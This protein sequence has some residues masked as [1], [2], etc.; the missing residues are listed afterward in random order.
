MNK[1]I[2]SDKS[3]ISRQPG[4]PAGT[5][6]ALRESLLDAALNLFAELGAQAT[7]LRAICA[8]TGV[9]PA[10]L[11]YYF[12]NKEA[13]IEALLIERI[14]P[15]VAVSGASLVAPDLKPRAALLQFLSEHMRNIAAHPWLP[16]LLVREVLSGSGVLRDRIL[17]YTST[18]ISSHL[19]KLIADAQAAGELRQ[20]LDPRLVA[21]SMQSLCVFTFAT[22]PIWRQTLKVPI[23][24]ITTA[25]IIEHTLALLMDGL[26][27]THAKRS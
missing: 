26:E 25:E 6:S 7:T 21:V 16:P 22:A 9:T 13:L 19:P 18:A 20:D 4:R 3:H 15:L 12:G 11:H 23:D 1:A 27:A 8:R 14:S 10:L 5:P 24:E 17:A 2:Y